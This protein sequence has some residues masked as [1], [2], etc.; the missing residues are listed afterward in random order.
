MSSSTSRRP[1]TAKPPAGAAAPARAFLGPIADLESHLPPEWWRHLFDEIYLKT[2]GDVVENAAATAAEVDQMLAVTGAGP[3][4]RILDLCCGQG[5][6]ALELAR[7]GYGRIQGVDRSGYLVRL[8]R[9]RADTARL[10]VQFREGDARQLRV[11][12]MSL[13][14]VMLMGNSFGYFASEDDDLKVLKRALRGLAPGGRIYLD[15]TDGAWMRENFEKRSW[16]WIDQNHFVCRERGLSAD[17]GRLISREVVVHDERGVIADQF[18]AE[19]LYDREGIAKLLDRA[20]FREIRF[21]GRLS[22]TSERNQDLGMM[23]HREIVTAVAPRRQPARRRRDRSLAV[24]VLLGDPGLPDPVKLNGQFNAEDLA[25]VERLKNALAELDGYAFTYLDNHAAFDADLAAATCDLAFN[26]CDEGW[27]ND[28]FQELHV[29]ARLDVLGMPYTGAGP[30]CLAACYDKALVRAVAASLDIPVPAETY[31][32]PGD[33]AATLPG[34]FPAIL[35]PNF[36]DSSVGI[37]AE[38]IV[39]DTTGLIQRL[40]VLRRDFG[41]RPILIQEF[42]TGTE[43]TVGLIGN[44]GVGFHVLPVLEVDYGRLADGL[45]RILGYESKYV[46]DSSYWNDIRY[47]EA[48]LAPD[49][50]QEMVSHAARL[51][52]RLG[53]RDYARFD[54]RADAAG[55]IRLLEANPNPGWCWDGKMNLAAGLE[56]MRYSAFLGRILEAACQRLGIEAA[57]SRE[58]RKRRA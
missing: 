46:P 17:G 22:A 54:F 42:L 20:G 45:P 15:L 21:H 55:Q 56:G 50:L 39:H 27:N 38:A 16:E 14:L 7:R 11:P 10:P 31:L 52:E 48:R 30:A 51:F 5:R 2:D 25:T 18:Y 40:D 43:Y 28:A 24:T 37:T 8:A 47:V 53:C 29:P 12:E 26:L 19:R 6:H 4:D 36:G 34:I 33:Q 35:K 13:D 32:R 1:A 44:P 23:A 41:D 3:G 57:E 49:A 9:R 58:E